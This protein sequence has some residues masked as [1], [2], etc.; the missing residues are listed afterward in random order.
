MASDTEAYLYPD[1]T[2]DAQRV[3]LRDDG[4]RHGR[5]H[6]HLPRRQRGPSRCRPQIDV[7]GDDAHVRGHFEVTL[8]EFDL[9]RPSLMMVKT[10][11]WL[12]LDIDLTAHPS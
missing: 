12:G 6:A 10:R 5:G 7:S 8:S 11:D 1:V 3:A 9:E 2:F 4:D